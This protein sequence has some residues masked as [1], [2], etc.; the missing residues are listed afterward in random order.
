MTTL[1]PTAW[2]LR[3]EAELLADQLGGIDAWRAAVAHEEEG[4]G[5]ALLT[6]EMRLDLSRR[7]QA[8]RREESALLER[9]REQLAQSAPL[10][11]AGAR[12]RAVLVHRDAWLR[13][14]VALGLQD[15]GVWV[16]GSFEDG[17][18][19]IGATV[20]EQPEILFV[21]DR[22]P[23][24]SGLQVLQRARNFA[25]RTVAGAQLVELREA[26]RFR[27]AGAAVVFPRRLRPAEIAEE[28]LA[29]LV[30]PPGG[31]SVS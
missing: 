30:H 14:K 18:D 20:V 8:R 5:A 10:R 13:G 9:A 11:V 1:Q 19:A 26:E 21:E 2:R 31:P 24:L 7:A 22:L 3:S 17:A 4:S 28:L 12:P 16:V 27:D 25:P 29:A 6:R 15:R 23:T